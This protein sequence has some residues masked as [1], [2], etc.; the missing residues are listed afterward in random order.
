MSQETI[1]PDKAFIARLK[2]WRIDPAYW[3]EC[4][5]DSIKL[6]N[7]QKQACDEL[8]KIIKAKLALSL[9]RD[10]IDEMKRYSEFIGINIHSGMGVGKDFWLALMT[11]YVLHVF[12]ME[13]GQSPHVLLTA[14]TAKQLKNVLLR[15]ISV[16]LPMS[17]KIP[18]T[19]GKTLLEEVF[20]CQSEKIFR[21][22]FGG[23][24]Y[25]AEAVTINPFASSDVQ[26]RALTGR[27]APYMFIGIDE[28]AGV[29]DAVFSNLEGTLTGRVNL[30][31]MIYNPIKSR[32]YAIQACDDPKRWLTLNWNAEDTFFDDIKYDI[33][34]QRNVKTMLETYGRNSNAYRIR[35]LGLPPLMGSDMFFP[36]DWVQGAVDKGLEPMEDDLTIMGVDP[37]RGGDNSVIVIRQGQRIV[38]IQRFTEPDTMRFVEKVAKAYQEW[39]PVTINV[40][41][42]GMG[43]TFYDRL[44]ELKLPAYDADARRT[45][46]DRK[47][48]KLVRDELWGGLRDKFEKGQIEIPNDQRLIDQ[49]GSIVIKD[50]GIGIIKIPSKKQMKRDIGYSPDEADAICLTY[51]IP[52]EILLM[53]MN[54]PDNE[55]YDDESDIPYQRDDITGY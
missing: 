53:Q 19:N 28:A 51:A 48:Y 6:N 29:P 52:D 5:F 44:K 50:Y 14:N 38:D 15:Q 35:V 20:V 49:L 46:R 34:L 23:K 37:A 47:R 41:S 33:P 2:R 42:I 26:A 3:V 55:Y 4:V 11:L 43:S 30:I 25:F 22:A 18:N 27:H 1:K 32:G 10:L 54:M 8:G 31:I 40:D 17:K 9:G 45:A 21:K 13:D 36:W 12:P 24:S 7:Y 16:L 39:E